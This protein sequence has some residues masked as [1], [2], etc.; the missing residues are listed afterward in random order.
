M[1]QGS[2]GP[3]ANALGVVLLRS[4]E[5]R[6][7]DL[8]LA[9]GAVIVAAG[10]CAK[11][12]LRSFPSPSGVTPLRLPHPS[13]GQWQ[14]GAQHAGL[15]EMRRLYALHSQ[16]RRAAEVLKINDRRERGICDDVLD[17]VGA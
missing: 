5:Q 4:L 13:R 8:I 10:E 12:F 15:H 14:P 3:V 16:L 7:G 17:F 1:A 6:L 11:R 2:R 9:P